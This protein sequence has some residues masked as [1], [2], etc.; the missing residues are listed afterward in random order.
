MQFI[1]ISF[2]MLECQVVRV[3]E[4]STSGFGQWLSPILRVS[5]VKQSNRGLSLRENEQEKFLSRQTQRF[6]ANQKRETGAFS[7]GESAFLRGIKR[8]APFKSPPEI[9]ANP[10]HAQ[11]PKFIC[12]RLTSLPRCP[13]K[14]N[15]N[16]L[17]NAV[18]GET[19]TGLRFP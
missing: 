3:V 1:W 7:A 19:E 11:A 4:D 2:Q 13:P 17:H 15:S 10:P 5:S 18:F 14:R 12:L 16:S 9:P 8:R 6:K